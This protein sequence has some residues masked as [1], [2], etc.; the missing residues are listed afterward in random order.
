MTYLVILSLEDDILPHFQGL[1]NA[2]DVWNKLK[3]LHKTSNELHILLLRNKLTIL[4]MVAIDSITNHV[5]KLQKLK[6][7]SLS[8]TTK[9]ANS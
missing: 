9:I 5:H 6:N 2:T 3:H 1:T 4:K 7:E 8:T